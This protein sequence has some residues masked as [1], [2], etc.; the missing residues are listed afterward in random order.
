M[1]ATAILAMLAWQFTT[2]TTGNES[3]GATQSAQVDLRDK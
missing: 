2:A 1:S 3:L